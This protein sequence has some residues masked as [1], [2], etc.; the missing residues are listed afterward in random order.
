[1]KVGVI[2]AGRWGRNY[3]RTFSSMPNVQLAAIC[4]ASSSTL[5]AIG[6]QYPNAKLFQNVDELITS[7]NC[8]AL[9]V[10]TQATTHIDICRKA[11]NAGLD[12]LV[13][14]PVTTLVSDAQELIQLANDRKKIFMVAHTFL[15]NPAVRRLKQLLGDGVP[16]DIYFIKARRTHLGP[17]RQDV[18]V[19]WDLAPHDLSMMFYLLEER[20]V[21]IQAMGASFL[22]P[23]TEDVAFVNLRFPSGVI[24]NII[25]SWADSN[26]ERYFDVVGSKARIA[27]DDLSNLEPIRIFQKG[28]ALKEEQARNFGEFQFVLRDGDIISPRIDMTEPLRVLCDGFAE[29]VLTRQE[30]Y[31]NGKFGSDVVA[32]CQEIERQLALK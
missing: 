17:I 16:G 1:M 6:K 23:G 4:D 29:A 27:F 15:F 9:V 3:I 10:A 20:P 26:K 22:K 7:K 21:E 11:L 28:V 8:D 2:G 18:N 30:P 5:E 25:L 14:K 31:S 12:L 24:G 13:E 19:V 32:V